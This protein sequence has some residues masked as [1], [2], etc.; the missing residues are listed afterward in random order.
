MIRCGNVSYHRLQSNRINPSL[1]FS[2]RFF[3]S[4]VTSMRLSAKKLRCY[5]IIF[6]A[7]KPDL[8]N[9]KKKKMAES[10]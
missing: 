1:G 4:K 8:G 6:E 3:L 10:G 9:L 2:S 5:T 7:A